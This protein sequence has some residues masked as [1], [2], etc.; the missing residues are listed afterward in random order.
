MSDL[1]DEEGPSHPGSAMGR[2]PIWVES[3]EQKEAARALEMLHV[4]LISAVIDPYSWKWA[5]IALHHAIHAFLVASEPADQGDA[6]PLVGGESLRARF[7]DSGAVAVAGADLLTEYRARAQTSMRGFS[8]TGIEEDLKRLA[9][10]RD[11]LLRVP[12][13]WEMRVDDL[14]RLSRNLLAIVEFLG[15]NPGRVAWSKKSY[16]D[17]A[18]VKHAATI[19]VLEALE[20]QYRV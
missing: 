14:P 10:Y 5:L 13:R 19:K 3:N 11:A 18:R 6:G 4:Q 15:W 17:L 8:V 1:G 7:A 16:A 12:N 2:G 20:A 9:E